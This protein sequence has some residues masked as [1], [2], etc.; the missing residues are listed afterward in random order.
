MEVETWARLGNPFNSVFTPPKFPRKAPQRE[1][2]PRLIL[3]FDGGQN[4]RT[5]RSGIS[6]VPWITEQRDVNKP[7]VVIGLS[8]KATYSL[9]ADEPEVLVWRE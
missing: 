7:S 3:R 4:G 8:I 5:K 1:V 9:I 6:T 2:A